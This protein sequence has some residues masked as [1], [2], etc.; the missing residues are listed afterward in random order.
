M[1]G[2]LKGRVD[3]IHNDTLILDVNGVGY[4]VACS[5]H[6]LRRLPETNEVA[7][8]LIETKISEDRFD[9]YGF[10]EETE[11][12][13]YRELIK[14][15]GVSSKIALAVLSVLAPGQLSSALAAQDKAAFKQVSGVGPKLAM[16]LVTE[17]KDKIPTFDSSAALP[18]SQNSVPAAEHQGDQRVSDALSA[19]VNLGYSRSD[20]Y[21]VVNSAIIEQPDM[22][23]SD[24]IRHGLK[25]LSRELT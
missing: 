11:R 14:V 4:L 17:L 8:L 24:L 3:T 18:S 2:K 7:S 9:L 12:A 19:L 5:A 23:V 6:T 10:L 16:R 15:N 25:A 22:N 1:I 20:A 13:W 21:G